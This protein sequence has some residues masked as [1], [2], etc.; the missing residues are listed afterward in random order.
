MKQGIAK[1]TCKCTHE[2]QDKH[3]G[4]GVRIANTTAK[5]DNNRIEV[6]CTVCGATHTVNAEQVK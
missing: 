3:C 2:Y 4:K 1:V 6:R 5:Q